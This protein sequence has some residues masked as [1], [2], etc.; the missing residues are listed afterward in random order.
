MSASDEIC[1]ELRYFSMPIVSAGAKMIEVYSR[2][3]EKE[4]AIELV[5][6]LIKLVMVSMGV[7]LLL[8]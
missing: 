7:S 1:F 5:I 2:K 4:L 8:R 3:S 6:A